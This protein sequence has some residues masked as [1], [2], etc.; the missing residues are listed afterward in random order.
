MKK[1]TLFFKMVG[2]I[3]QIPLIF[4]VVFLC[5]VYTLLKIMGEKLFFPL[6]NMRQDEYK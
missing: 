1:I 3:L 2:I 6:K 5:G 4:G